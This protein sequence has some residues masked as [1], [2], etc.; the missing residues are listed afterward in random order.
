M[1]LHLDIEKVSMKDLSS[2]GEDSLKVVDTRV[3]TSHRSFNYTAP[4][5]HHY[6]IRLDRKVLPADVIKQKLS[7]MPGFK[8]RWYYSGMEVESQAK[9]ADDEN[10]KAF[11]R[12]RVI[13]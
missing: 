11:V 3:E 9:W 8:L 7:M 1:T 10:K 2:G 5:Q 12:N 4:S 6:D 13:H